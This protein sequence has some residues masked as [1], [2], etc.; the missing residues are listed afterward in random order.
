LTGKKNFD[1][2]KSKEIHK[3]LVPL[4]SLISVSSLVTQSPSSVVSG[5]EYSRGLSRLVALMPAIAISAT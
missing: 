5:Q 1:V 2:L 3:L 4:F